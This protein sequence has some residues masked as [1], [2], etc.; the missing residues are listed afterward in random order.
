VVIFQFHFEGHKNTLKV[1]NRNMDDPGTDKHY[2]SPVMQAMI[3]K[4]VRPVGVEK[5]HARPNHAGIIGVYP[6]PDS[7]SLSLC[8]QV[9]ISQVG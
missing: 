9:G 4:V 8:I 7:G 5:T 2:K 6:N 3:L 1:I